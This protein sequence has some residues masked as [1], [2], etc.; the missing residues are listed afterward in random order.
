M[1]RVKGNQNSLVKLLRLAA[2]GGHYHPRLE[3]GKK[4]EA[5]NRTGRK[6][7]H[8]YRRELPTWQEL[9]PLIEN[10][11]LLPNRSQASTGTRE[12]IPTNP[13]PSLW[14]I[15]Y[16]C[17]PLAKSN[18]KP[19]NKGPLNIIIK[20]QPR[21][22]SRVGKG[23]ELR[24]S[25]ILPIPR[26][27]IFQVTSILKIH[28]SVFLFHVSFF[29]Y[30]LFALFLSQVISWRSCLNTLSAMYAPSLS[31]FCSPVCNFTNPEISLKEITDFLLNYKLNPNFSILTDFIGALLP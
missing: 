4:K 20:C 22:Y 29:S 13:S 28:K 19:D 27:H 3:D 12:Q 18:W 6:L 15:S 16:W 1:V 14:E 31:T 2:A 26:L 11:A 25:K 23:K 7:E 10:H 21:A 24:I 30:G 5:V 8:G 17:F 9:C